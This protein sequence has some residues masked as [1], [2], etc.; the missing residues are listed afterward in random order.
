MLRTFFL[1]L[2]TCM[3]L[4][5]YAGESLSGVWQNQSI[6][7]VSTQLDI[8]ANGKFVLRQEHTDDLRRDYLC[9]TLSDDGDSL[10]LHVGAKKER[11]A[12]GQIEEMV[13]SET[14]ILPVHQRSSQ[15]LIVDYKNRTIVLT[16]GR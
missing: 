1:M 4:S 10:V 11:L 13:G 2:T 15:T 7:G 8:A 3:A 16:P 9:G 6:A 14:V 12:D 5:A